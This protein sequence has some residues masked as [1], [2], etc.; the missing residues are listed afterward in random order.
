MPRY[1]HIIG[2]GK[3]LPPKIVTN[4]ELAKTVDT[5]D[6]WIRERTGIG[7]R[8]VAGPKESTALLG[9]LAARAAV[10]MANV[11]PSEIDLIIVATVSPE[12]PFPRDGV[13]GSGRTGRHPRRSL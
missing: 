7:Q 5:S 11:N 10:E 8:H 13:S 9:L 6:Q 2:W 3:Y 1:A 12:Y 4:D